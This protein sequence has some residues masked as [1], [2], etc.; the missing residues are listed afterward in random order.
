MPSRLWGEMGLFSLAQ[1]TVVEHLR[2]KAKAKVMEAELR[3]L[4]TWKVFQESKLV[5]SEQL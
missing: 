1:G 3:E 2:V 4:K 5:A